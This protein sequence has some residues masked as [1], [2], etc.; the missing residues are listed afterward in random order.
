MKK[1][2]QQNPFLCMIIDVQTQSVTYGVGW[3]VKIGQHQL[4]NYLSQVK[5]NLT[6]VN[7]S[8]FLPY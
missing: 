5:I 6:T 1:A 7:S 8:C 3:Q 2:S 4:D